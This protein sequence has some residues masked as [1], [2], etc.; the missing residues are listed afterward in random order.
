MRSHVRANHPME[1]IKACK[2]TIPHKMYAMSY[3]M[4][5]QK[6]TEIG[7]KCW[8]RPVHQLVGNEPESDDEADNPVADDVDGVPLEDPETETSRKL[9]LHL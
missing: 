8:S 7:W 4:C 3:L 2:C 1:R 9:I 5:Y 6:K